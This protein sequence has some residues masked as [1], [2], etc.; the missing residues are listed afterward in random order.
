[1]TNNRSNGG[2]V[3]CD[4]MDEIESTTL[5]HEPDTNAMF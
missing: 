5:D 1:M 4:E 2:L 3:V